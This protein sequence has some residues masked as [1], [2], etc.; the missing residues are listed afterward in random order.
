MCCAVQETKHSESAPSYL[1]S[2]VTEADHPLHGGEL[3][4]PLRPRHL[5][6]FYSLFTR[7]F[8][9]SKCAIK[10]KSVLFPFLGSFKKTSSE[11]LKRRRGVR[12]VMGSMH[13]SVPAAAPQKKNSWSIPK[14]AAKLPRSAVTKTIIRAIQ[15]PH[16]PYYIWRALKSLIYRL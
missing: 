8:Q 10:T 2:G 4:G 13:S 15:G 5:E 7:V 12:P 9:T 1:D 11:P 14:Q 6:H 16:F 3:L